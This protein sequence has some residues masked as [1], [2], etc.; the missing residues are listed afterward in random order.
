MSKIDKRNIA[1]KNTELN[2]LF[3]GFQS[4]QSELESKNK[5]LQSE[6]DSK[7]KEEYKIFLDKYIQNKN[8]L[9]ESNRKVANHFNPI[10]LFK[11]KFDEITHINILFWIFDPSCS[12]NQGDSY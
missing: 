12:H 7:N 1:F 2:N 4:L 11:V 3:V 9:Y 5:A 6:L 8:K 10:K